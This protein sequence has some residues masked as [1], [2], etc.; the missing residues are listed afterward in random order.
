MIGI[1]MKNVLFVALW[2]ISN[3]GLLQAQELDVVL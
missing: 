1:D 3:I 2:L